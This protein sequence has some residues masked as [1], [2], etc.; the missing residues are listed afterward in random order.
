M[1]V[2]AVEFSYNV[3]RA[4]REG[5]HPEHAA[6][7]AALTEQGVLLAAGPLAGV[8]GGLLVYATADRA[9]LDRVLAAEPY[10][11]AG[12]V[13]QT[14]VLEWRPG[15]GAWPAAQTQPA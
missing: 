7:L 1:A 6:Y 12:L 5:A 10:I 11:R 15:K 14:R 8:N 2:F 3:D 9:E 13:A 4:G